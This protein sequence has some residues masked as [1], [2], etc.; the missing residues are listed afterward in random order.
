VIPMTRIQM[1]TW[2]KTKSLHGTLLIRQNKIRKL[3]KQV[4]P[5]D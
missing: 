4:I 3:C 5:D 1:K 2:K